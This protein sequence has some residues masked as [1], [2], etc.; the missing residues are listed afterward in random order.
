MEQL[1]AIEVAKHYI[2]KDLTEEFLIKQAEELIKNANEIIKHVP[3]HDRDYDSAVLEVA[4]LGKTIKT[5]KTP[6]SLTGENLKKMEILLVKNEQT[7]KVLLDR[8][9]AHSH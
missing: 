7:L 3:I 6:P 4:A 1:I 2:T 9:R 8:L 5:L